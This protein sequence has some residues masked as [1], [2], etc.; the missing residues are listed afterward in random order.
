MPAVSK[1]QQRLMAIAEHDP[2]KVFQ[3]NMGVLKMKKKSL[4]DFTTID[5]KGLPK[6]APNNALRAL[7]QGKG[8]DKLAK[9]RNM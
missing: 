7:M 6:K 1:A 9:R 3:K 5:Y 4:R 2:D 8:L